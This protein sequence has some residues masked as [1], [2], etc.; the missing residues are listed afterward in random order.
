MAS[1]GAILGVKYAHAQGICT[2]GD[3]ITAWPDGI[4]P[5]PTQE[6][7]EAWRKEYDAAESKREWNAAILAALEAIDAKSIR[8]LRECDDAR[9]AELERQ[10]ASLRDQLKW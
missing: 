2:V 3:D 1:V 9:I 8:A 6:Q 4:G 5:V 7:I 10:A